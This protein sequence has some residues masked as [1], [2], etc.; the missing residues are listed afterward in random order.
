[1]RKEGKEMDIVKLKEIMRRA[2]EAAPNSSLANMVDSFDEFL[3]L[4]AARKEARPNPE[5]YFQR[6]NDSYRIMWDSFEQAAA[7]Y[8]MNSEVIQAYFTNPVN[9]TADE[10]QTMESLKEGV[11]SIANDTSKSTQKKIRNNNKKVKI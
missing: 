11:R 3:E 5:E 10:W 4:Y 7:S 2:K 1:M 6:L 8:G 9:F